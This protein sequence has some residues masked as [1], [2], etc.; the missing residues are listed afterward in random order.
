M[1]RPPSPVPSRWLAFPCDGPVGERQV[2]EAREPTRVDGVDR[3]AFRADWCVRDGDVREPAEHTNEA[4]R[5]HVYVVA[6]ITALDGTRFGYGTGPVSGALLLLHRRFGPVSS[7]DK[8]LVTGL[9][10]VGAMVGD[11]GAGRVA[12][13][14]GRCPR[15]LGTAVVFVVGVPTAAPTGEPTSWSRSRSCRCSAPSTGTARSCSSRHCRSRPSL[16]CTL[17]VRETK[18]SQPR[19]G[20][21][22][23][24]LSDGPWTVRRHP[25][26]SPGPGQGSRRRRPP[27]QSRTDYGAAPAADVGP[28]G[29]GGGGSHAARRPR[30]HRYRRCEQ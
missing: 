23:P 27:R 17:R 14:I 13:S 29:P 30:R 24:A 19:A 26:G 11:F 28:G 12:D 21:T 18:V 2:A 5:R 15:L 22:P 20:R 9:L 10:L 3:L 16:T 7:F 8:E 6:A 4:M 25:S 1:A